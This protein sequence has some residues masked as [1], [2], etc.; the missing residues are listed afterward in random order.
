[1]SEQP[2]V[3][4][5]PS[6]ATWL[7]VANNSGV[8]GLKLLVNQNPPQLNSQW[9]HGGT[10]KSAIV[11]NDVLYYAASCGGSYCMNAADPVTGNVLW[12]SSEHL[13]EPALAKPHS[14]QRRDLHRRRHAS[15][16]LR[17][18]RRDAHRHADGRDRRQHRAEHA[19][20]DRRR[21]DD[22]LHGHAECEL[23]DFRRHRL[24]RF[25]RRQHLYDRS[26]HG[27]LHGVG[28]VRQR[29]RHHF[30]QWLRRSLSHLQR[31]PLMHASRFF[32]PPAI[33]VLCS[34]AAA[35]AFAADWMQFGYDPAHTG[36]NPAENTISAGNVATLTTALQRDARGRRRQRAGVSVECRDA[37]RNEESPVRVVQE[38]PPDGDRLGGRQRGLA[39]DDDR[40]AADYRVARDR[41][42]PP[43]RLQLRHRRL[44]AQ[45]SGR[46]RHRDHDRR[47]AR[48]RHVEDRCRERRVGPHD[49]Q[50]RRH[51]LAL[52]RSPTATSATA[53]TT[54]A[55]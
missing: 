50:F 39:R 3:W 41:S 54:R 45:V 24:R 23:H 28:D 19:A 31:S 11:A 1:M 47:L 27:R 29:R 16:S 14:R 40:H 4:V 46:R 38:R 42:R 18:Q 2:A 6:G 49:R 8:S 32:L 44:R 36:Y 37:E 9:S 15:A 30:R 51:E 34:L 5:D 20:D 13:G 7:L 35:D 12:T 53:A 48:A 17:S 55:T 52:C 33:A 22:E 26:D 25:A 10:A 21:R 43:I